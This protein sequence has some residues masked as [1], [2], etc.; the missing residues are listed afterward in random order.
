MYNT[1]TNTVVLLP[2]CDRAG[3][4]ACA[5]AFQDSCGCLVVDTTMRRQRSSDVFFSRINYRLATTKLSQANFV[6]G[7]IFRGLGV[8][9]H[10]YY[11]YRF[12]I[13]IYKLV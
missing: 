13:Y 1:I 5:P 11:V 8:T 12:H 9:L 6:R 2:H 4:I 7:G 3:E 10:T